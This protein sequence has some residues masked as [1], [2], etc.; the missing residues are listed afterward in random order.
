MRIYLQKGTLKGL[1]DAMKSMEAMIESGAM[2]GFFDENR[3]VF[4]SSYHRN[5]AY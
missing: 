1:A 2:E 3:L 5:L 4:D